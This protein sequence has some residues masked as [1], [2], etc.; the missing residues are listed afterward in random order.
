MG[1]VLMAKDG[2]ALFA[3]GY[4]HANLEHEVPNAARTKFR[5][6]SITKQ[7]AALGIM[8]LQERGKLKVT[9]SI[10][11]YVENC[12]DH[13]NP[14]TIH[15]LLS[16]TSGIWNFTSSPDYIK[17][18][19]LDSPPAKTMERFR[20]R[21]LEFEPG[22]KMSYSNSGYILLAF[23]LEKASGTAWE[24]Y[25]RK[26]IFD[27]A[28]MNDSGHDTHS[29]ILK[30]RATGYWFQGGEV[31]NSAYHDMSIPIGGGDLYSTVEDLLRWDQALYTEK[32]ATR[33]SLDAMFTPVLNDYGYG[34][35]IDRQF[36]RKRISHGGGINGFSTYI[37][38]FPEEKALVVVLANYQNAPTGPIA[39]DLAAILF[40][41]KYEIP[42]PK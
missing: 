25:L 3:K 15:H 34:W 22:S 12:P 40:G 17:Q 16:H 8:Q 41:K 27:P 26:N 33:Q 13:W 28:G 30:H 9:D 19:M 6:G 18:W 4:G 2:K 42:K 5:L 23:I 1:T 21:P 20:D 11:K 37:S 14:V 31:R 24:E 29:A 35:R 32:L 39:R 36:G 10:C 38:R 7:F